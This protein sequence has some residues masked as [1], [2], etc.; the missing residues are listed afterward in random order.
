MVKGNDK[1][2]R[3]N[4]IKVYRNIKEDGHRDAMG[5]REV[6]GLTWECN[7]HGLV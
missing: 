6:T 4:S 2:S 5:E 3:L 1:L 7:L